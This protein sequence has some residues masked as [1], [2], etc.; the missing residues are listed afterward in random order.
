MDKTR[1]RPIGM[2]GDHRDKTGPDWA[3]GMTRDPWT[4]RSID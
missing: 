2:K 4:G 1:P 3:M